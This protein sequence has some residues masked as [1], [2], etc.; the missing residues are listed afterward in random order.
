VST[1]PSTAQS[2]KSYLHLFKTDLSYMSVELLSLQ[3]DL[4][5]A[6]SLS[7]RLLITADSYV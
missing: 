7:V 5:D 4:P 2:I 3:V 6:Q 1:S